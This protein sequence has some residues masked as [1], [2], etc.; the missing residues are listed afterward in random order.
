M[1]NTVSSLCSPR[2]GLTQEWG[3]SVCEIGNRWILKKV[4][5]PT[6]LLEYV[7]MMQWPFLAWIHCLFKQL[8][9]F[10]EKHQ[11]CSLF[12]DLRDMSYLPV[13][14]TGITVGEYNFLKGGCFFFSFESA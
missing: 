12:I 4:C 1:M 13:F 3:F 10:Q 7:C 2:L 6:A 5:M 11:K 8:V 14:S 9:L